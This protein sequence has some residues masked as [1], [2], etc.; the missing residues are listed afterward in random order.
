MLR[1]Y[2]TNFPDGAE[3]RDAVSQA[4]KNASQWAIKRPYPVIKVKK[5]K[6]S[7]VFFFTVSFFKDST[8]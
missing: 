8:L 6:K 4:E 1:V 5:K 7:N 2:N 3:I